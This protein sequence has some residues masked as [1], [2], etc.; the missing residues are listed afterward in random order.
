M[1]L[2]VQRASMTGFLVFDYAERYPEAIAQL[3]EWLQDG[4]LIS[5][6]EVVRTKLEEFP[7][8]FLRLF[9]GENVGKLILEMGRH[10]S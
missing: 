8:V 6:E 1:Q 4:K 5:R 7:D 2:L 10:G 3:A 9:R